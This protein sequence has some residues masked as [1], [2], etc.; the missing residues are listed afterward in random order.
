MQNVMAR[1]TS[2][3]IVPR[4]K[5]PHSNRYCCCKIEKGVKKNRFV[6]SLRPF[7]RCGLTVTAGVA[8]FENRLEL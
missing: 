4:Q 6:H 2:M 8:V 1:H 3:A 7:D 5:G